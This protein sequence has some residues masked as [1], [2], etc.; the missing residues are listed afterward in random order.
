MK[1]DFEIK[2]AKELAEIEVNKFKQIVKA[3]GPDTLV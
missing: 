2:K 3:I 1:V